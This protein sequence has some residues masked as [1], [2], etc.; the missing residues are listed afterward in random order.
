VGVDWSDPSNAAAHAFVRRYGWT[1]P[2][3]S[4]P[5]GVAGSRYGITGLPIGFVL[6]AGGKIVARLIGEQ[7]LT[8]LREALSAAR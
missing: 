8:Q 2:V 6:N 4:D 1:F 7:T 3:L 5:D